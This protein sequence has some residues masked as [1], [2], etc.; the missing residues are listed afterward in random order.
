MAQSQIQCNRYKMFHSIA[1]VFI[2]S[3]A[4]QANFA[5]IDYPRET[6]T[7]K[8]SD[9]DLAQTIPGSYLEPRIATSLKNLKVGEHAAGEKIFSTV[10]TYENVYNFILVLTLHLDMSGIIHY[11]NARNVPG[12]DAVICAN[13]DS[14]GSKVG[15]VQIRIAPQATARVHFTIGTH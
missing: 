6:V 8:L 4:I 1:G 15:S 12:S 2:V 11:I 13:G 10:Y 14:L 3:L 5:F 7:L 9:K